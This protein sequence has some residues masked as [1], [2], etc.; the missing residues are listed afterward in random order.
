M[1][2][3]SFTIRQGPTLTQVAVCWLKLLH[4]SLISG[5]QKAYPQTSFFHP[6]LFPIM[7][8]I[9]SCIPSSLWSQAENAE[10]KN[11]ATTRS[12]LRLN[13]LHGLQLLLKPLTPTPMFILG[14][15]ITKCHLVY[16]TTGICTLIFLK[17]RRLKQ[18]YFET[19]SSKELRH[20]A[21]QAVTFSRSTVTEIW[22]FQGLILWYT[23]L[24]PSSL[25]IV[26]TEPKMFS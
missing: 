11:R 21:I 22:V 9:K 5:V 12:P 2:L 15:V 26:P 23:M 7:V 13:S 8:V 18:G 10:F 4:P 3:I 19:I 14:T 16:F 20:L 24:F 17:G 25:K 6:L 1:I